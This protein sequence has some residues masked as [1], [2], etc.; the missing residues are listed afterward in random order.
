MNKHSDLDQPLPRRGKLADHGTKSRAK[1]ANAG[2]CWT[3]ILHILMSWQNKLFNGNDPHQPPATSH[4]MPSSAT[5]HPYRATFIYRAAPNIGSQ[6]NAFLTTSTAI[7]ARLST[8][9]NPA[10][11]PTAINLTR[12]IARLQKILISP[13]QDTESKLRSSSLEREKVGTV[14]QSGPCSKQLYLII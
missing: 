9:N 6:A 4:V 10:P 3:L 13:D 1:P 7:M 5:L 8:V 2:N 12:M 14:S 11:D